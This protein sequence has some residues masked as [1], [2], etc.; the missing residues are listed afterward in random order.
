MGE[1]RRRI[2]GLSRAKPKDD[3]E[4]LACNARRVY[5]RVHTCDWWVDWRCLTE[6]IG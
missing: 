5:M 3:G 4:A 2:P 6:G 1:N